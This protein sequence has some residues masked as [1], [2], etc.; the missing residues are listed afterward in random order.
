MKS[1]LIMTRG[2]IGF[3]EVPVGQMNTYPTINLRATGERIRR[4]RMDAGLSVRDLSRSLLLSDVQAVYKW[5][6]GETLPSLENLV[7]LSWLLGVTID[8]ILA[9]EFYKK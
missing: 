3:D 1:C 8:Q 9:V 2:V 4:L 5:Q 6:R 7:L